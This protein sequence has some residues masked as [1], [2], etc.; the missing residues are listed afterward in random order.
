[1]AELL[2]LEGVHAGYGEGTVLDACSLSV[3]EGEAVALLGR[4]G[5]GKSVHLAVQHCLQGLIL[6]NTK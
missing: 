5:V 2:R 6:L 3:A 1:M 4:N